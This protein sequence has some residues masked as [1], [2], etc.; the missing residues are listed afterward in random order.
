M[1]ELRIWEMS[2][3][4]DCDAMVDIPLPFAGLLAITWADIDRNEEE[5]VLTFLAFPPSLFRFSQGRLSSS[6]LL[7]NVMCGESGDRERGEEMFLLHIASG[8][9]TPVLLRLI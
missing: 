2:E 4:Y 5:R 1:I 3:G 7:D 9:R 6:E 8:S